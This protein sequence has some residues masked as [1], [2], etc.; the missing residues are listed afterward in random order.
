MAR[1][2]LDALEQDIAL[3][4]STGGLT[5]RETLVAAAQALALRVDVEDDAAVV[6]Q[7]ARALHAIL[8][9]LPLAKT[10]DDW[11]AFLDDLTAPT[12]DT[13]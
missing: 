10:A 6:A 2:C 3:L 4:A 11:E 13:P 9:D 12:R 7:C 8:L 1:G 5:G